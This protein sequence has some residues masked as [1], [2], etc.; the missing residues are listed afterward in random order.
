MKTEIIFQN[1]FKTG[2]VYSFLRVKEKLET[3]P[4]GTLKQKLISELTNCETKLLRI[5][6][7]TSQRIYNA[8]QNENKLTFKESYSLHIYPDGNGL[9]SLSFGFGFTFNDGTINKPDFNG[10]VIFHG[11]YKI[12][13]EDLSVVNI[14]TNWNDETLASFSIHT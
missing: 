7:N 12:F 11:V 14:D 3:L 10:G 8:L 1:D 9:S 2:E 5:L 4:D 6:A 13:N